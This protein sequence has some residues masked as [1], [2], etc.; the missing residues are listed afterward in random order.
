MEATRR[1]HEELL[2]FW[3]I[4]SVTGFYVYAGNSFIG[5][6]L[7]KDYETCKNYIAHRAIPD[8]Y[9]PWEI[10][11]AERLTLEKVL[12]PSNSYKME[13]WLYTQDEKEQFKRTLLEV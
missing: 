7:F 11:E 3:L 10:K 2:G 13:P 9:Q 5:I 1:K 8:R 6:P 4:G 12:N